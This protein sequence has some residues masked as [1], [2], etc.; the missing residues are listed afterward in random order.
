MEQIN[1]LIKMVVGVEKREIL[2]K[3]DEEI[4]DSK[5]LRN[6]ESRGAYLMFS[7][8]ISGLEK[9]KE[10]IL[11]TQKTEWKYTDTITELGMCRKAERVPLITK[12]DKIRESNESLADY[13]LR[14]SQNPCN[15]CQ[16]NKEKSCKN[17][18]CREEVLK[19]LNEKAEV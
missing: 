10:F 18:D 19:Y 11:S 2:K 6:G 7:G 4:S 8:K 9:A 12:G 14:G 13:A 5:L 3:I 17:T 15:V 16:R 1:D